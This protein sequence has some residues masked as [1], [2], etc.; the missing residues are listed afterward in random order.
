MG[1]TFSQFFWR[2]NTIFLEGEIFLTSKCKISGSI[3]H[4]LRDSQHENSA[5]KNENIILLTDTSKPETCL[6]T[7]NS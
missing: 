6:L 1:K 5:P 2:N 4:L 7:S 3:L